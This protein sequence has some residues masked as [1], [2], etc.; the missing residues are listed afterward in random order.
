MEW[1]VVLVLLLLP[2]CAI[3]FRALKVIYNNTINGWTDRIVYRSNQISGRGGRGH[4]K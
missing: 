1:L 3:N 2:L 4:L